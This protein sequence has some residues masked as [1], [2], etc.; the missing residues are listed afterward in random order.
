MLIKSDAVYFD[1]YTPNSYKEE[2]YR[3]NI[4][5]SKPV[6]LGLD[7]TEKKQIA[8]KLALDVARRLVEGYVGCTENLLTNTIEFGIDIRVRG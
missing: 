8:E 1:T 7:V 2:H 5:V 3:A 4:S 6:F